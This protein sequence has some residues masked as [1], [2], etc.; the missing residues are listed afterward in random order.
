MVFLYRQTRR[1]LV[2]VGL[3][4]MVSG[5]PAVPPPP[6]EYVLGTACRVDLYERGTARVYRDIFTRLRE[7]ENR[8]SLHV[9]DSDLVR[10]NSQAGIGPVKV[11]EDVIEVIQG[12]LRCADMTGGA[13]DPAVEPLAA[14]W[15]IGGEAPRIPGEDEIQAVLPLLDPQDVRVD[16]EAGTVFLTRPGMGLDLGAIAKG[17][18]ADEAARIIAGA[19]IERAIVDLGGNILVYGTKKDKSPWR[20][21]IQNPLGPRDT[22]MGIMEVR[23]KTLVTS[24]VYERFFE[25]GGERYHHIL[26]PATGYPVDNGLLSVTIISEKSMDADGLSTGVFVLGYE[27][28]KALVESLDNTEA[29]FI[30][31]DRSVRGTAGALRDFTLTDGDYRLNPEG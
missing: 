10:I 28:G 26:S 30:F 3:M 23:D 15:G 31:A 27:K 6:P 19:R 29:L 1:I 5:C 14:L 16:R 22:Y 2:A 20:V 4:V 24:G 9:R 17:Y 8:M 12:A 11:H 25:E 13:F 21:G 18:A 7:I